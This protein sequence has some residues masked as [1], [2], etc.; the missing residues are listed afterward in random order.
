[1]GPFGV[2]SQHHSVVT[3]PSRGRCACLEVPVVAPT[4]RVPLR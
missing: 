2:R 4:D 1:L 3:L